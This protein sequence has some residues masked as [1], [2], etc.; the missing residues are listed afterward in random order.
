MKE[1]KV[2][3]RMIVKFQIQISKVAEEQ[4]LKFFL[5]Q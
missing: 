3:Q 1:M 4:I 2:K 5:K